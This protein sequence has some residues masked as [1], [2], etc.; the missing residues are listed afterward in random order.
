VQAGSIAWVTEALQRVVE[1]RRFADVATV[2]SAPPQGP[3][4]LGAK[5]VVEQ[6]GESWGSLGT[7]D[8]DQAAAGDAVDALA[9]R[10]SRVTSYP[11][12]GGVVEV[13]HEILKPQPELLIIGAGHIAVPL[14]RFGKMVGFEVTV[15]DDREK[16]ANAERFPD[17]DRVIAADFGETLTDWQITLATYIVIIT[18]AHTYDE[19]SL[20]IILQRESAYIGMIGS[21]RRVQVVLRTLANEGYDRERLAKVRAPIGLDIGAETPD[22]IALAIISEV[23]AVRRGGSGGPLSQEHRPIAF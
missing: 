22:E 3:I 10:R 9:S 12:P 8:L 5:L 18:R 4:T 16:Y 15:V 21:R 23:V 7:A 17:A 11:V 13:F 2:I 14:A 20:R 6:D 19:E 1:Q